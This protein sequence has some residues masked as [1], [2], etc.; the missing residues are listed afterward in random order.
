MVQRNPSTTRH[1]KQCYAMPTDEY[2]FR[3]QEIPYLSV[4]GKILH[5]TFLIFIEIQLLEIRHRE[6]HIQVPNLRENRVHRQYLV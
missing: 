5:P 1:R 6:W 4:E 3:L 2:R